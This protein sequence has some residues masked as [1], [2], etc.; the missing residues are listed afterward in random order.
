MVVTDGQTNGETGS[1]NNMDYHI[2]THENNVT[3]HIVYHTIIFNA[4]KLNMHILIPSSDLFLRMS[5]LVTKTE[6][7]L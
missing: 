6:P 5:L 7:I 4:Y 1:F 3:I 2:S